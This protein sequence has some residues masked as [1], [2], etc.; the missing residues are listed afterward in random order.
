MTTSRILRYLL[1]GV[2]GLALLIVGVAVLLSTAYKNEVKQAIIAQLNENLKSPIAVEDFDFSLISNFPFASFDLK[3]LLIRDVNESADKDTLLQARRVSLLFNVMGLWR[4]DFTIRRVVVQDGVCKIRLEKDGSTN[5]EFWKTDSLDEGDS[6][7]KLDQVRVKDV[8]FEYRD[9]GMPQRIALFIRDVSFT[10]DFSS[11]HYTLKASGS[12]RVDT[13]WMNEVNWVSGKEVE[14]NSSLDINSLTDTYTFGESKLRVQDV[15]FAVNGYVQNSDTLSMAL[16]IAAG[17][18]EMGSFLTLLPEAL[19]K[20]LKTYRSDGR[21]GFTADIKGISSPTQNPVV[22]ADFFIRNGS[23]TPPGGDVSLDKIELTGSLKGDKGTLVIPSL[24]A[25]LGGNPIQA[26]LKLENLDHPYLTLTAKTKVNLSDLKKLA[27]LDTLESLS[28]EADI[29]VSFAG[30]VSDI[31]KANALERYSVKSSGSIRI[32]QLEFGLKQNPLTFRGISGDI[33]LHDA[34]VSV[35]NLQ[36]NISSS[37]FALTGEFRNFITFLLIPDQPSEVKATWQS[38]KLV[39]DEWLSRQSAG[40]D[41]SYTLRVNPRLLAD[42]D[43]RIG[44]LSFRRFHARQLTG[45]VHLEQEVLAGRDLRFNAMSGSVGMDAIVNVSRRDSVLISCD[46]T[47]SK[48]DIHQLFYEFENFDQDVMTDANVNGRVTASVQ[49][50]S[51]WTPDLTINPAK[52]RATCDIT[53]ENGELNDFA[54]ILAMSKY[55][56]LADLKHIRFSTLKNVIS[57]S[58]EKIYIPSMEIRSSAL[59]LSGSGVHT[60]ENIVDYRIKLLLSD[61]LGKK[62]RTQSEFGE[63]ED[64]GLG[65]TQIFLTMKGPVDDPKIGYDR[66]AAGEKI[67]TDIQ[68]EKQNLKGMLKEEFG[69]FKK[70]TVRKTAPPKK[71]EEMQIEW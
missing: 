20:K 62:L 8:R 32:R 16:H 66:K 55:L 39:L 28:G 25:R 27:Q 59:N 21:F 7:V 41:T 24:N 12:T 13:L 40:N 67:R 17:E 1:Y 60:F 69:S 49:F 37:D 4:N 38:K 33:E 23:L 70:D 44:E 53:I 61:V 6:D 26:S 65:R 46:A 58:D 29:N 56:K 45:K 31:P 54:P 36:G 14:W 18:N 43:V 50:R 63:I 35:K 22:N 34:D 42:L 10:G 48:L 9:L 52:A 68:R 57:I 51:S 64:D 15:D 71:K 19:A 3:N 30:K 2:I 11:E 47:M 5:Y